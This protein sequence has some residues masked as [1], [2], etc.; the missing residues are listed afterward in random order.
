MKFWIKYSGR[1]NADCMEWEQIEAKNLEDAQHQAWQQ[2]YDDFECYSHHY[3][4][5][6]DLEDLDN[7]EELYNDIAESVIDY[8]VT[9]GVTY[10]VEYTDGSKHFE[11]F[12]EDNIAQYALHHDHVYNYK[13]VE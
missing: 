2:A 13:K 9:A 10:E 12:P 11:Q 5:E 1:G 7:Q 4:D 3:I 6:E 8:I